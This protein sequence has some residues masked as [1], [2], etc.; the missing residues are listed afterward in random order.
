MRYTTAD[1]VA[2]PTQPLRRVTSPVRRHVPT[3]ADAAN[4]PYR[5][6]HP[7]LALDRNRRGSHAGLQHLQVPVEHRGVRIGY[8]DVHLHHNSRGLSVGATLC[9]YTTNALGEH[10]SPPPFA[11]DDP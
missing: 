8:I 11:G 3:V 9:L 7:R 10:H 5:L 4:H 1:H 2:D 6:G